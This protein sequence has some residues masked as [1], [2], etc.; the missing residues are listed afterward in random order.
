MRVTIAST[1]NEPTGTTFED[2]LTSSAMDARRGYASVFDDAG[3]FKLG[4]AR[5]RVSK[6][7]GTS[8]DEGD[9]VIDLT[10]IEAGNAPVLPYTYD[11]VVDTATL[12]ASE[13][14]YLAGQ[15]TVQELLSLDA[16][17]TDNLG[18]AAFTNSTIPA[19][20]RFKVSTAQDL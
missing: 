8:T 11:E 18:G 4:S 1:A 12:Y 9:L 16:R 10:C 6:V 13:P 19:D 20:Q 15:K 2:D 5:F 3:I 7:T 14:E 17:D